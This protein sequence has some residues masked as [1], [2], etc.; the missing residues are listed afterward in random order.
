MNQNH[1]KIAM[2]C[3]YLPPM[4]SGAGH[5][6]LRIG[7][8]LKSRGHDIFF[9]T[10]SNNRQEQNHA[11]N[12]IDVFY[13][14]AKRMNSYY[15]QFT[16]GLKSL[17]ILYKKRNEF[18]ILFSP[19]MGPLIGF[20]YKFMKILNKKVVLRMSVFADD[21]GILKKRKIGTYLLLP[22]HLADIIIAPSTARM[23]GVIENLPELHSKLVRMNNCV[24]INQFRPCNSID[25]KTHLLKT[26]ELNPKRK[27]VSYV[28][29]IIERKGVDF[30]I[31]AW[32]EVIEKY[33]NACLLLVG[34]YDY[35]SKGS[36]RTDPMLHKLKLKLEKYN[37]H[38]NVIFTGQVDNVSDYL[39]ISDVFVFASQAEG[40]PSAP[41]EA[42]ASGI[43]PVVLDI[44]DIMSDIIDT[45]ED[46]IIVPTKNPGLFASSIIDLLKDSE[47]ATNLG[48]MARKKICNNFSI[49]VVGEYYINLFIKVLSKQSHY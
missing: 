28:G 31:D 29:R 18:D 30:L 26:L 44:K 3:P 24:N 37:L 43:P 19:G 12:G 16:F 40:L 32:K 48:E 13:T 36:T 21:P 45:G 47:H 39:K 8:E 46:G 34:P 11:L 7:T 42:M 9:V 41:I 15:G 49:K 25:E 5:Q 1:L 2:L 22:Y 6:A 38:N 35:S 4:Y 23:K 27:Y 14:N 20:L 33:N 17:L 10:S